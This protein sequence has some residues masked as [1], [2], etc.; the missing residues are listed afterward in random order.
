MPPHLLLTHDVK[1]N[2]SSDFFLVQMTDLYTK[3]KSWKKTSPN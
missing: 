1:L 3:D 2:V